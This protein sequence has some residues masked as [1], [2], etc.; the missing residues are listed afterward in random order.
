MVS[1]ETPHQM[2]DERADVGPAEEERD[3]F[4][5]GITY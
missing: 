5:F 3:G 1:A 4:D 2:R